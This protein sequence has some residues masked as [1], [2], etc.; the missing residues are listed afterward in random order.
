MCFQNGSL[1]WLVTWCWLTAE[2]SA[3]AG[4]QGTQFLSVVGLST[5][6]LCFLMEWQLGFKC[7]HP[8]KQ[9]VRAVNFLVWAW[10]LAQHHFHYIL[11]NN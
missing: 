7:E 6:C 10:K 1:T 4:D 9:E 8:M 11:L 5:G 3:G 2:S